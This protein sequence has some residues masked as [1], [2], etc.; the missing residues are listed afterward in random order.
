MTISVI[1]EINTLD[2][3]HSVKFLQHFNEILTNDV[4]NDFSD[5]LESVPIL[6]RELPEFNIVESLAFGEINYKLTNQESIEISRK[7]LK[8]LSQDPLL[9]PLLE[10]AWET[11]T[12]N[13]GNIANLLST[14]LLALT[15]I[16]VSAS[17]VKFKS[18][19]FEFHKP[20]VEIGQVELLVT[21][22][23][24]IAAGKTKPSAT[25]E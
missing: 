9:F 25:K 21:A 22:L 1:E 12:D 2:D 17:D 13:T 10:K 4:A 15:V 24:A 20:P 8:A 19:S 3:V 6:V 14:T 7:I 11:Y 23:G 18:G 5:I 16:V